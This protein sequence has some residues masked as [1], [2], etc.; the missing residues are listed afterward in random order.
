MGPIWDWLDPGW[1]H[2]GP[3]NLA[4][5]VVLTKGNGKLYM[6]SIVR[7][8]YKINLV[9]FS[10]VLMDSRRSV[11]VCVPTHISAGVMYINI[12]QITVIITLWHKGVSLRVWQPLTVLSSCMA[13]HTIGFPVSYSHKWQNNRQLIHKCKKSTLP[14]DNISAALCLWALWYKYEPGVLG[15]SLYDNSF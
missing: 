15:Y 12:N 9:I 3:M 5:W 2:V 10:F 11:V 8:F 14:T 4:I 7:R 6:V 13:S 1:P